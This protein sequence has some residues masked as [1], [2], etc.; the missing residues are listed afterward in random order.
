MS[1]INWKTSREGNTE[2]IKK[3][4]KQFQDTFKTIPIF[5]AL[6]NHESHPADL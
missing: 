6:G 4:N 5:S 1:H 3:L 2:A